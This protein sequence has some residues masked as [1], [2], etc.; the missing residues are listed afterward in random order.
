MWFEHA[1][2][3]AIRA[4]IFLFLMAAITPAMAD[5]ARTIAARQYEKMTTMIG[6]WQ[7]K[8][9]P[10]LRIVFEPTADGSVIVERWMVGERIHS[11]TVYHLN[12][13]ALMATHYCPQGNQ[14]RLIMESGSVENRI[15]FSFHDA[16]NLR[17]LEESHQHQLSFDLSKTEYITR[18][19]TYRQ[20]ASSN[21]TAMVLVRVK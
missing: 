4:M 5:E 16:T 7:S 8:D 13:E 6:E 1:R 2:K 12:G 15:S 14:P 9:H 18:G 17:S 21:Q 3:G 11:M 20:G 19:E 10:A